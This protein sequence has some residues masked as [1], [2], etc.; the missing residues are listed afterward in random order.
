MK[1]VLGK[2]C[3]LTIDS[4]RTSDLYIVDLVCRDERVPNHLLIISPFC[5]SEEYG[6]VFEVKLDMGSKVDCSGQEFSVG[7]IDD[8]TLLSCLIDGRLNGFGVH[9]DA[10]ANRSKVT[11]VESL[12]AQ[13][14]C[15]YQAIHLR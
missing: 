13:D 11:Y 14:Q 1:N 9:G 4:A 5:A 12:F 3:A 7:D 15:R 6:L 10:I 2:L 8:A